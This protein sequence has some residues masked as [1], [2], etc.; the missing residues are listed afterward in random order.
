L[1]TQQKIKFYFGIVAAILAFLIIAGGFILVFIRYQKRLLLKQQELLKVDAQHK[2]DLLLSNIES[3]EAE[4]MRIAKDIHDEIG[5]IFSTLSLSVN[6]LQPGGTISPQVLQTANH[7]IEMGI[8]GVRRIAHSIIPF[9]LE[10]FGLGHA[11]E[12]HFAAIAVV[13]PIEIDFVTEDK[14]TGSLKPT[15]TLAIYRVVQELTSNCIKYAGAKK[16]DLTLKKENGNIHLNYKDDGQGVDMDGWVYK[17]GI[18][19]KNIESRVLVLK[20][21]VR[22]DSQKGQGFSCHII[23]PEAENTIA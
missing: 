22:F 21:T 20:G 8:N 13:S 3:A 11:L 12:N 2:A 18:G 9:E 10:L 4:R 6:Q 1:E 17:K 19:L 5:S 23:I 14:T 16:I 7:L 15:A